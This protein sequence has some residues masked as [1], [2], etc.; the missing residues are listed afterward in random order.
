MFIITKSCKINCGHRLLNHKGTCSQLHGHTYTI[1]FGLY[2]ETML[3]NTI[4]DY[5]KLTRTLKVWL[6]RTLDH[7]LLLSKNDP[8]ALMLEIEPE[9]LDGTISRGEV[10]ILPYNTTSENIARY[11]CVVI[12]SLF[13]QVYE[14]LQFVEVAETPTTSARCYPKKD[15]EYHDKS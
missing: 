7:K 11:I 10:A 8:I 2:R 5:S 15:E 4:T 6:F 13:P 9:I 14:I 1:T 12:A 3:Y